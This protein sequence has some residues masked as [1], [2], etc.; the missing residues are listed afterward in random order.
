MMNSL[1]AFGEGNG[2]EDNIEEKESLSPDA[3][4][5]TEETLVEDDE[6]SDF[7]E[8]DFIFRD[9]TETEMT[10]SFLA[11]EVISAE[12]LKPAEDSFDI[13]DDDFE[14]DGGLVFH[15]AADSEDKFAEIV[16]TEPAEVET[17]CTGPNL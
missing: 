6:L 13:E 14:Y 8:D 7:P 5:S 12:N 15:D 2:V 9:D 17:E 3:I 11:S 4:P 16:E 1:F 10:N